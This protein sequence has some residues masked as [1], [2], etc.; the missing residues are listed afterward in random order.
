MVA[1]T[2]FLDFEIAFN[3]E[4]V[5][6]EK[7]WSPLYHYKSKGFYFEQLNRYYN[8]FP[9][10]NIHCIN[11]DDLSKEPIIVLNKI[12]NF[13]DLP[14]YHFNNY[15]KKNVNKEDPRKVTYPPMNPET[16]KKLINFYK[17]HNEKLE[18][19]LNMK[20]CWNE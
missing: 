2:V 13:L 9:K 7:N 11:V 19:F 4:K 3:E 14:K 1:T 8:L 12:C 6:I 17:P 15:V 5:R 10:E 16:R 20:F 18:S